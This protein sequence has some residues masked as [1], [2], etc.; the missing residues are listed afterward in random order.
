[1]VRVPPA[2]RNGDDARAEA[3]ALQLQARGVGPGDLVAVCVERSPELVAALLGVLKAGAAY[4]PLDPAYPAQRLALMLEDADCRLVLSREALRTRLPAGG[5]EVLTVDELLA[6][7]LPEA[8]L[9]R[10]LD[11]AAELA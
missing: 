1:M 4:V 3:L 11:A 6:A 8:E 2:E 7:P 10:F 9:D 5:A